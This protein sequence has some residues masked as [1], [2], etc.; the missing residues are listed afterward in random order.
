MIE[1]DLSDLADGLRV[2][3]QV[4]GVVVSLQAVVPPRLDVRDL[5]GV[6]DGLHVAGRR[7]RLRPEQGRHTRSQEV[8]HYSGNT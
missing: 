2:W 5:H 4:D 1:L 3:I 6:A 7:S 8:A